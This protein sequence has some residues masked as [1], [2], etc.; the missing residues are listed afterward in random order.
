[1]SDRIQLLNLLQDAQDMAQRLADS[2]QNRADGM[3]EM[4][5]PRY[6]EEYQREMETA[7]SLDGMAEALGRMARQMEA[8]ND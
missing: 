6:A 7:R 4:R 3:A 2:A 8:E 5:N 1:M